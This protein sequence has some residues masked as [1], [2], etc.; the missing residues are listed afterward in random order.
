MQKYQAIF[1]VG[2]PGSGKDVI[3][4]DISS[5]FNI[6]EYA[7]TQIDEMLSDDAAFKRA[8]TEKQDALLERNSIIVTANSFDLNF[9]STKC[10]LESVGYSTHL[11]FVEANLQ[12]SY[13]RLRTRKNLKESLDK[14]SIGNNN[15]HSI[16][17]FFDSKVIVD[18]SESLDLIES[19]EFISGILDELSFNSDLTI[20]KVLK[21]N[22]KTKIK[23]LVPGAITGQSTVVLPI[24]DDVQY[25]KKK[26]LDPKIPDTGADA[27]G[28]QITGWTSHMESSDE[29]SYNL[30]AIATGPMQNIDKSTPSMAS[31]QDKERFRK[32]FSKLKKI[33]GKQVVPRGI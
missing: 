14:L 15:K 4:R 6:I 28:E 30:S 27:R 10:V 19:R 9:V 23:Q 2:N 22:L 25:K 26:K 11:I 17:D 29:P 20:E 18:N 8:K 33:N 12:V 13:D 3:I 24:I 32:V 7:S 1:I 5:N 21:L 16:L 31:D